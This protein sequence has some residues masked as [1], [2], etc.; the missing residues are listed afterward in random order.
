MVIPGSFQT[1]EV[2]VIL[3]V[4]PEVS[5][6][7][8][9]IN[10]TLTPQAVDDPEWEDYGTTYVDRG[11]HVQK[12]PMQQPFFRTSS[13]TSKIALKDGGTIAFGF[14]RFNDKDPYLFL[15][16]HA[17]LVGMDGKPVRKGTGVEVK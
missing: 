12:L 1:R 11:G 4:L 5:R 16:V 2:G 9:T 17:Q 8:S 13:V 14:G 3:T 7:G 15:F 10:L 6:N